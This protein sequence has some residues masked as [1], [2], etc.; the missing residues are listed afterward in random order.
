MTCYCG[1]RYDTLEPVKVN[2]LDRQISS[3]E[4]LAD[5]SVDDELPIIAPGLFDIQVNGAVGVELSS[6]KLTVDG[7]VAVLQKMLRD[8]VFRCCL[9]LTTNDQ[10]VMLHAA[11]TIA[12]ALDAY[13]MYR[14]VVWGIHLEGPF[15]SSAEGAIGAHP[16]RFCRD[17]SE[18]FIRQMQE[19][20]GGLI[21]LV[22]LTPEYPEV[23]AFVRFLR[24]MGIV[25]SIGHTDANASQIDEA[26]REGA[27]LSTHLSNATRHLLPKWEN[28]FFAQLADD[29]LKA[30][31][32]VDGFHIS[33]ELV[34]I[35]VRTKGLENLILISDQSPLAGFP[36]GKY[37]MELCDFEI[38]PNGKVT[39]AG[40]PNLL[41]CA[42]FPV[43]NCVMNLASIE[44]LPLNKVYPLAST[45][46][47]SLLGAPDFS[48]GDGDFL[49]VG[50][51]ADFLLF[52]PSPAK[53]G[54]LGILD[55]RSFET[56]RFIFQKI[57]WKG[58]EIEPPEK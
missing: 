46:P 12:D 10:K 36:P 6:S 28:Y 47:A 49:Q 32:I 13:P 29:R 27:S 19:C 48:S 8:G 7:V 17:Y 3:I 51:D 38:Q 56:G 2:V 15:I 42:S 54:A 18:S 40:D 35:I 9:T 20:S 45:S 24:S 5:T 52:T 23:G 21:K 26:V 25:V 14:P 43:S 30:S 1:R 53:F 33:P 31:I 11:K 57:L 22:T 39:L 41:A 4:Y 37:S 55:G 50:A 58:R 44:N 34:R 16:K